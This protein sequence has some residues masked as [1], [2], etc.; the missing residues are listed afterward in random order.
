MHWIKESTWKKGNFTFSMVYIDNPK[1]IALTGKREN[2]APLFIFATKL[3]TLEE[4]NEVEKNENLKGE[5]MYRW[6]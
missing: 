3:K 5:G 2:I 6:N 4:E 1:T